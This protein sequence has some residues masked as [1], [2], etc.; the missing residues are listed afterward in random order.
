[1]GNITT[2]QLFK[3]QKLF[4]GILHDLNNGDVE[5]EEATLDMGEHRTVFKIS[6]VDGKKLR[7]P[8][9]ELLQ[10]VEELSTKVAIVEKENEL[11]DTQIEEIKLEANNPLSG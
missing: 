8:L 5:L 10:K 1:M 9:D 3:L 11:Q 7:K 4:S 2:T 6:I